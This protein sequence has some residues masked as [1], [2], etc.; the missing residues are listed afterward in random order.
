MCLELVQELGCAHPWPV[1]SLQALFDRR[2][3]GWD[4]SPSLSTSSPVGRLKTL[5]EAICSQG[6]ASDEALE[7]LDAEV[8][9]A[10]IRVMCPR[11]DGNLLVDECSFMLLSLLQVGTALRAERAARR[12]EV[13]QL[14][15][16]LDEANGLRRTA[17]AQ[18]AEWAKADMTRRIEDVNRE[19]EA[20]LHR[21]DKLQ[22]ELE[23]VRKVADESEGHQ[24]RCDGLELELAQQLRQREALHDELR[25]ARA[26]RS[27]LVIAHEESE[28]AVEQLQAQLLR[29]TTLAAAPK[30]S[31]L[32]V[33]PPPQAPAAPCVPDPMELQKAFERGAKAAMTIGRQCHMGMLQPVFLAWRYALHQAQGSR[34]CQDEAGKETKERAERCCNCAPDKRCDCAAELEQLR[35]AFQRQ[36]A[37]LLQSEKL[38][39]GSAASKRLQRR[40]LAAAVP[41]MAI[42]GLAIEPQLSG[43]W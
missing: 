34:K 3:P 11:A 14:Q 40:C 8:K 43:G 42:V 31:P 39:A 24:A 27:A 12:E 28:R 25:E 21:A 7:E 35:R 29:A 38:A 41:L 37:Q 6:E 20:Q 5:V 1:A 30:T 36:A 18:A 26:Q 9:H 2:Y 22:R 15:L 10:Q 4:D 16:Q 19:L 32:V 23:V 17:V 13:A 33:S